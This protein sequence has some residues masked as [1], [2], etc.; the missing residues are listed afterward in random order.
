MKTK[1][2]WLP[3]IAAVAIA[4]FVGAKSFKANASE[5][6]DLLLA[7]VEAL[8]EDDGGET[9]PSGYVW[10]EK[11]TPNDCTYT[12]TADADGNAKLNIVGI[13]LITLKGGAYAELTYTIP[14]G[15]IVCEGRNGDN[16]LCKPRECP[17]E[18]ALPK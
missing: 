6:N 7:N 3:C 8:A 18:L 4:T 15:E 17:L 13:G 14:N 9:P 2:F 12:V 10:V 11:R 1:K 5:S 16:V